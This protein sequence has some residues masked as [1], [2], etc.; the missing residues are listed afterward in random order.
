MLIQNGIVYDGSFHPQR[1][2]VLLRGDRIAQIGGD[3]PQTD[4]VLDCTGCTVV[5]GFVDIHIHGGGG[6]D[7]ADADP[8]S[9]QK[10]SRYLAR[11]GVTSFCP[12][13]MTLPREA[14]ETQFAAVEAFKGSEEGARILGVRMEGPYI[15]MEKKG[16][17]CG[18]WIRPADIEEFRALHAISRVC[19]V[20]VA[21]ETE[22]ACA[23]AEVVSACCTVSAGH[24][25]ATFEQMQQ[26]LLHGFS[27]GTHLFNAMPPIRN[28]DPGAVT[29]LLCSDT[30]TA[31]LI[32]DGFH[33][34][35]AVVRMAFRLL[36]SDRA[37]VISDS[38]RAAGCADGDYVLGGQ[39]VFVRNGKARLSDGTIAASTT[40]LHE[41]F[42][43]LLAW[44]IPFADA[45]RACTINP[46]RVAGA[47][48][49]I[50]SIEP[51]KAADLLVL[52]AQNRIRYTIA[53]G[54]MMQTVST[55]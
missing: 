14:L 42:C 3:L 15:S 23:F 49:H 55:D 17:Q 34:H 2:D 11:C 48:A 43:N 22:G 5:P 10:M 25:A 9:L 51:G 29:A 32:C 46:A 13:S 27:H 41:E 37:V 12:A 20:D 30:A 39:R 31:E 54:T 7:M 47:D 52:D 19:A 40:N 16:A 50:G 21:P 53:H 33:N 38:M 28:R 44:G 26:G 1:A 35:P 8:Q 4:D 45:L 18:D 36:G 6:G 24:T